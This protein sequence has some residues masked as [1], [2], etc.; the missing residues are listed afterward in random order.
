[1]DESLN[2]VEKRRDDQLEEIKNRG[3]NAAYDFFYESGRLNINV[4]LRDKFAENLRELCRGMDEKDFEGSYAAFRDAFLDQ[5]KELLD[6][7]L[8]NYLKDHAC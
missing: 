3:R 5:L 8:L 4:C 1:M 2:P 6:K 7:E